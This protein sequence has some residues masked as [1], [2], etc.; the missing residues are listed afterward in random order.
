MREPSTLAAKRAAY[1]QALE[2][3]L[4]RIVGRLAEMPEVHKAVLFGSYAQGRRDLFTDIDLIVVMDSDLDFI[5]RSA[6]LRQRFRAGVDLDLFV[7]TPQEFERM[8][9]GAFLR[10]A[11][12]TGKVIYEKKSP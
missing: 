6:L 4:R 8:A 9:G 2:E 7:Y 10:H 12:S 3:A 11:L 5:Q 1:Q